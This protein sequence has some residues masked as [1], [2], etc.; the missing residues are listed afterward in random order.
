MASVGRFVIIDDQTITST[1]TVVASNSLELHSNKF[2][3]WL[4]IS[5][6]DGTSPTFD[7]VI[8]HSPDKTNWVTLA[9]FAQL[10]ANGNEAIFEGDFADAGAG[11]TPQ[12]V[13][14]YIRAVVTVGGTDPTGD[15]TCAL[16]F[17]KG[18]K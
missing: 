16:Y 3:A 18:G 8:S 11:K 12:G 15:V 2:I 10:G 9:T 17:D 7:V 1:T 5:A 6:V 4:D 13:F 14:P